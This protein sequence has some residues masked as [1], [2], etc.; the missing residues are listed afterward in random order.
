[1]KKTR[2]GIVG[3]TGYVGMELL[4]LLVLH[5]QFDI[6]TL[7]SQSFVGQ[8]FSDI[9]PAFRGLIDHELNELSIEQLAR[10]CD[11]VVTALPH[12]ISSQVVPQLLSAGVKV[13]DHS[14]DFR[15]RDAGIY[16]QA[17][18]LEHPRPDMLAEAVYGMPDIYRAD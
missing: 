12:G 10:E 14:G 4:R 16:E 3:A 1:M 15:Y 7:V 11:L 13:L 5:G 2:I 6:T 17:Y 18:K 8:R 9:Y